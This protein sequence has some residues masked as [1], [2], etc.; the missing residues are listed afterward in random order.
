MIVVACALA[1]AIG[2][3]IAL[4][5]GAPYG[6]AA[7]NRQAAQTAAPQLLALLQL[8]PG[9]TPAPTGPDGDGVPGYDE[10]TPNLVDAHAW[11]TSTDSPGEIL[12]Y[13]KAHLPSDATMSG[14]FSSGK[15]GQPPT[16]TGEIWQLPPVRGVLQQRVLVLTLIP[17]SAGAT[18]VRTDGEAVWLIPR[19]SWERIPAG[20]QAVTFVLRGTRPDGQPGPASS[21]RTM[22]GADA[23]RLTAMINRLA[24]V[25]PGTYNC[26]ASLASSVRLRFS[27]RG[28]RTVA[29]AIE[30]PTG[31]ASVALTIGGRRGRALQ[32]DPSVTD[33]LIRL[34]AV[35][36]CRQGALTAS[37]SRPGRDGPRRRRVTEVRVLNRS[38]S[39]C[40]LRGYPDVDLLGAG[41]ASLRVHVHRLGVTFFRQQGVGANVVLA[42]GSAAG[43][44]LAWTACHVA[45][46]RSVR[47]AL[48]GGAGGF[49]VP[50]P[51]MIA[52]CGGRLGV[53]NLAP[54]P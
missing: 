52:P 9:T 22:R 49:V 47:L 1:L 42:A 40:R 7:A 54:L 33:D 38:A 20:V 24:V 8:P 19:A 46:A 29:Q 28:G 25:Q 30:Q 3:P 2:A 45:P 5:A 36:T 43:F 32:D 4:G 39:A 16:S 35:A 17:T 41:G 53:G 6:N 48:P 34:G 50:A 51:G 21:P 27:A 15:A 44:T 31:C 10:A 12:A 26:P 37:A 13:V 23:R 14:S 11:W 18:D